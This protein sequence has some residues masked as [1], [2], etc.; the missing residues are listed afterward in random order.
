M[1]SR[2]IYIGLFLAICVSMYFVYERSFVTRDFDVINSE[3]EVSEEEG[4]VSEEIITE[5]EGTLEVESS[6]IAE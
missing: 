3:E 1:K 6:E 5:G 4:T 2:F